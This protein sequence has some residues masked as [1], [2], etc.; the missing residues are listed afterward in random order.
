MPHYL[1]QVAYQ[2]Y[3]FARIACYATAKELSQSHNAT[4]AIAA[5]LD[6]VS[7]ITPEVAPA[8]REL[9]KPK[10]PRKFL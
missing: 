1:L 5:G 9:P 6:L 7:K 4:R 2:F 8:E 10:V 3:K